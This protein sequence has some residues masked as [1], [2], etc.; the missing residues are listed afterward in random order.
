MASALVDSFIPRYVIP[1]KYPKAPSTPITK[2]DPEVLKESLKFFNKD[3]I[4]RAAVRSYKKPTVSVGGHRNTRGVYDTEFM[5]ILMNWLCKTENYKVTGQWHFRSDDGTDKYS[6]IV[7]NKPGETK[8]VLELETLA[9][10]RNILT[11]FIILLL[12]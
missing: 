4:K 10:S 7:I 1:Q 11:R 2:V 3:I 12:N 8:V 5:R 9:L 6:D